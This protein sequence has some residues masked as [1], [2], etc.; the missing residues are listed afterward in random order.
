[1]ATFTEDF[2]R[3]RQDFD[4]S[5][6]DRKQFVQGI[7]DSVPPLLAG[8]RQ[9]HAEMARQ[10]RTGLKDFRTDLSAGGAIFRKESNPRKQR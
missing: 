1:M 2:T 10:Q 6:A 5:L 9:A 4:Q 3:M 8:F 7:R